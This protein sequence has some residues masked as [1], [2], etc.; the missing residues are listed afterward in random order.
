MA[1]AYDDQNIF[2]RILRG[3]IPNSTVME[4]DHTLAFNDIA[5]QAPVHVLVIPKG[6]YVTLDHFAAQASE[7]E[8]VD[9]HRVVARICADLEVAPGM[10]GAGYRVISN[11]GGDGVQEVPHY[12]LHILGGRPLGRMLAKAV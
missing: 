12:H 6:A 9:F 5:P 10:G 3:E 2:A 8:I 7:A 1:Y 11:A 4:T